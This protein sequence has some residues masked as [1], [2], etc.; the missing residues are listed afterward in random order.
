MSEWGEKHITLHSPLTGADVKSS[1]FSGERVPVEEGTMVGASI[2]F[3]SLATELVPVS[4]A[5]ELWQVTPGEVL[6]E[7][8]DGLKLG[9]S[10]GKV[11]VE[12]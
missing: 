8:E 9:K 4:L 3:V 12:V 1:S 2:S 10:L 11:K 7:D 6:T 5:T